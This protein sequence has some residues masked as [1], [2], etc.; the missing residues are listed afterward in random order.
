MYLMFEGTFVLGDY[1]MQGIDWLVGVLGDFI[2]NNMAEGPLK[3]MLVDGI[4]GGVGGVIVFL[5]N[6]LILYFCISLMEDSGYM[7]RAAF[8]M[9]KVMHKMGLHGKSF[10]PLVMGFGCNVPAVMA[11]RT[12]ENRK[13]RLITMLINPLMSCS[14]RLPI[15]LLLIGALFPNHGGLVLISLYIVGILLA[16]VMARIF[17]RFIVKGDDTPFVME[18]PPYRL[19]TSKAIFRHTWEKGSQYLRKM[20]G[21][22]MLASMII[23]ALGYYPNHD[24]YGSEAEQQE[25]S[26]IGQIG[27]AVEPAI[28]PLGFDWK[29]GIGLLS[30]MGAKELVVSTMGVLYANDADAEPT[31][32]SARIPITPLV[33]YCYMLFVLIYFPCIATL[34]AIKNESGSWKWALFSAVYSTALAWIVSY[35]VYNIGRLFL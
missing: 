20:G 4:V 34:V 14:A 13:S 7:A 35:I 26:Y 2:R 32:L 24:A 19:P 6:I 10:I 1:P 29:L 3:D 5:P 17:N 31:A 28:R 33:A 8:I 22:I 21:I 25:N 27:K 11:S 16:V 15:Y 18:L 30:G 12:I 23:W 9:D